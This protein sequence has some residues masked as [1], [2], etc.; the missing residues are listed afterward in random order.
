MTD[1]GQARIRQSGSSDAVHQHR[2]DP[3]DL[4]GVSTSIAA[5]RTPT[6]G[7][8][9]HVLE[10]RGLA[11]AFG[12]TQAVRSC[13][14]AVAPGE[15]HALVGENGSGKSTVV[16]IL[17][18][19]HRPDAG[20]INIDG[21]SLTGLKSPR[22]ALGRGI[23]AAFQEV[24]VVPGQSVLENVWLG[25]D[26]L[27]R[28][29]IRREQKARRATAMLS[30]LLDDPP[31]LD[32]PVEELALSD[33]Q[34]CCVARALLREPRILILD[35]ATS[36]LDVATRDHLFEILRRRSAEG[37]SVIFISHRMDEINA[38]GDRIT[39]MRTGSTV[40]TLARGQAT[41]DDLVR[42]MTGSERLVT[43]TVEARRPRRGTVLRTKAVRLR[44]DKAPIDV[45]IR[46]G[47]LVGLAGLEGHGQDLFLR[48]LA[49]MGFAGG[50][51]IRCR[52]GAE[53]VI[54]STSHAAANGIAYLPRERHGESLFESLSVLKNFAVTTI[55]RDRR[56]GVISDRHAKRRFLDY[57]EKLG[58]QFARPEDPV[59]VL[60][61][62]NQ[63]KVIM[64][65]WLASDPEIL[66]LNDPTRGI[67]LGAKRDLYELLVELAR[68]G[69]AIVAVSTEVDEHVELMD[70]V[71]VF[72]EHEL[73]AELSR[74]ELS[75][76]AL[77]SAFFEQEAA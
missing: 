73:S 63:Q 11:K 61:G 41:T 60:S 34:A 40:A 21:Q 32:R 36:A 59:R 5:R 22:A 14:I 38:I 68:K 71:L 75:R 10:V 20:S 17:T 28:T 27:F 24:L 56:G 37:G 18:G 16:K 51:A 39:V 76:H 77:V 64:A 48:G 70:R 74:S 43:A 6:E 2:D 25:A 4:P 31:E 62:G 33:R 30:E 42:L 67:D 72:R 15:V 12:A 23:V 52:D 26:D 35:E 1:A 45:S 9:P 8:G 69:I 53:K 58:I 29:R 3:Q 50:E 66:L 46:A 47:E 44:P 55:A 57:A 19:V 13:T 7:V 65:R 49:G 54:G